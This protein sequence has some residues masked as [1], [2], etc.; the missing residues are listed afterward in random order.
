MT[1]LMLIMCRVQLSV[2]LQ[3]I[4]ARVARRQASS[5]QAKRHAENFK[6]LAFLALEIVDQGDLNPSKL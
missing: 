6:P 5:A 3:G 4:A 1:T 2:I